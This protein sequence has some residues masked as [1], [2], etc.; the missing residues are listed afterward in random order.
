M[1]EVVP[2]QR[3]VFNLMI[4]V[5]D[6]L[7]ARVRHSSRSTT[8]FPDVDSLLAQF[9]KLNSTWAYVIFLYNITICNYAGLGLYENTINSQWRA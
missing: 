5:S 2:N 9:S 4:F 6:D 7:I 3:T 1:G 8:R